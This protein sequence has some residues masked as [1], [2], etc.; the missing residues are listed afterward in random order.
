MYLHGSSL[1]R[2]ADDLPTARTFLG[3]MALIVLVG[4][5][6]QLSFLIPFSVYYIG[7]MVLFAATLPR[8]TDL[9]FIFAIAAVGFLSLI[10][11]TWTFGQERYFTS[12]M[13]S[14]IQLVLA[15]IGSIGLMRA[16][17]LLPRERLARVSLWILILMSVGVALEVA[18][19]LRP[20]SDQIRG[21]LY[22]KG[23]YEAETRDLA[24]H[25][26]IRP[27]LFASEP[28]H[29]GKF[30]GFA[31]LVSVATAATVR[32][33][34]AILVLSVPFVGLI[35]SPALMPGMLV[36]MLLTARRYGI[37]RL[38]RNP[39]VVTLLIIASAFL[40]YEIVD[41]IRT[42]LINSVDPSLFLRLIRPVYL[43]GRVLV[44]RPF[45]GYG[46]GAQ[47][48]IASIFLDVSSGAD[49]PD[50]VRTELA[51]TNLVWGAAHFALISQVGV[52]GTIIWLGALRYLEKSVLVAQSLAFWMFF[53]TYG[54]FIGVINTPFY[55]GP[56]AIVL[57][58]FAVAQRE[59][60]DR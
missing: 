55:W 19:P 8:R 17:M 53:A 30:Y 4:F 20:I 57:G 45:F 26:L 9:L 25:G 60:P 51:T 31:V 38:L 59:D 54:I 44:D 48:Q 15:L 10:R 6:L 35:A 21:M 36:A 46:I 37:A 12:Q 39:F 58:G 50:F 43:T 1:I 40:L 29:V 56:I 14:L 28:S 52:L 16:I 18:G 11:L 49:A 3:V 2:P 27:K 34:I 33:Q 7:G 5:Y 24:L 13:S 42:R 32:R 47:E 22:A 23:L 41:T